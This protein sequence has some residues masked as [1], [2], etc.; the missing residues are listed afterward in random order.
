MVEDIWGTYTNSQRVFNSLDN[1][2]DICTD[3][4]ADAKPEMDYKDDNS[5]SNDCFYPPTSFS[6]VTPRPASPSP[7]TSVDASAMPTLSHQTALSP[8]VCQSLLPASQYPPA[9]SSTSQVPPAAATAVPPMSQHPVQWYNKH[10]EMYSEPSA[11]LILRIKDQLDD[12]IYHCYG[13]MEPVSTIKSQST[14][15]WDTV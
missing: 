2:W 15:K 12:R 14:T 7:A 9:P 8:S 13:F 3:L 5:D 4:D 6:P 11:A 1:E 10:A